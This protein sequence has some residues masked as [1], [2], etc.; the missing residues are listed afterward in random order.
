MTYDTDY[1]LK[2][3][4]G[5]NYYSSNSNCNNESCNSNSN[6]KKNYTNVDFYLSRDLQS[7]FQMEANFSLF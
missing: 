1:N 3:I 7:P 4:G 2:S 6:N 5:F